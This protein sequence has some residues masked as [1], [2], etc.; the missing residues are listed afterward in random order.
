VFKYINI[1]WKKQTLPT[2]STWCIVIQ[3]ENVLPPTVDTNFVLSP[4][5]QD[6]RTDHT[7]IYL[8]LKAENF[9]FFGNF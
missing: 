2:K 6:E 9:Y 5:K 7:F 8:N 3:E 4:H 1:Y